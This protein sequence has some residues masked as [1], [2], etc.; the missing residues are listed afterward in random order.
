M[1]HKQI[2]RYAAIRKSMKARSNDSGTQE[3]IAPAPRRK[4]KVEVT[5]EKGLLEACLASA[6]FDEHRNVA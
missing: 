6:G 2:A 4:A 5:H 1:N 3:A